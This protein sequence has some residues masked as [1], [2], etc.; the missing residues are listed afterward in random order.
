MNISTKRTIAIV[1]G[2]LATATVISLH[3][4]AGGTATPLPTPSKAVSATPSKAAMPACENEDGSGGQGLPCRWV[5]PLRGNGIGLSYWLDAT[6]HIHYDK[7]QPDPAGTHAPIWMVVADGE[8]DTPA[9]ARISEAYEVGTQEGWVWL[10]VDTQ[11]ADAL[12]EGGSPHADTRAWERCV[13]SPVVIVCPDGY[14]E[15]L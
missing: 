1:A 5:A 3:D 9:N 10:K 12:A 6:G 2:C 4:R 8:E 7:D 15:N 14:V 11:F 13:Y